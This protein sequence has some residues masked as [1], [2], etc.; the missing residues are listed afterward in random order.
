MTVNHRSEDLLAR[1]PHRVVGRRRTEWVDIPAAFEPVRQVG[2]A[3]HQ[4]RAFTLTDVDVVAD[5]LLLRWE[6]SGPIWVAGSLGSPT[7]RLVI[8]DAS[9]ST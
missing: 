2:A 8:S 3:D 7:R 6:T 4:S 9:A 5:A 1:N